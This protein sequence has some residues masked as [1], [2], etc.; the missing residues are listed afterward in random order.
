MHA[1]I[2]D[3]S[4]TKI[5]FCCKVIVSSLYL[6][7]QNSIRMSSLFQYLLLLPLNNLEFFF[8]FFLLTAFMCL[9]VKCEIGS[10]KS[11]LFSMIISS[12]LDYFSFYGKTLAYT[13]DKRAGRPA[14]A[15]SI[16][17]LPARDFHKYI[18]L[19]KKLTCEWN[20]IISN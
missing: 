15:L 18:G 16:F 9:Y 2:F 19:E 5:I 20:I 8:C 4:T 7:F 17:Q 14:G 1:I 13:Y 6:H 3:F 12:L 11:S 10:E